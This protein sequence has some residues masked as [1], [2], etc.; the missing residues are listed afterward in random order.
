MKSWIA[1][2]ISLSVIMSCAMIGLDKSKRYAPNFNNIFY[3]TFS[4]SCL[5]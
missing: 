2:S 4:N 5:W 3:D 1:P